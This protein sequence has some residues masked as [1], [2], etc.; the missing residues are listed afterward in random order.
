MRCVVVA[1]AALFFS[2]PSNASPPSAQ[3]PYSV[4]QI[5]DGD[6]FILADGRKVRLLGVDAP[7]LHHPVLPLQRFAREAA[8][9]LSTLLRGGGILL[10]FDPGVEK[11]EYGRLLAYVR[12]GDVP[13]NERMV[14]NGYAYVYTRRNCSRTAEFLSAENRARRTKRG[15]W[16]DALRHGRNATPIDW[17]TAANRAGQYVAVEGKIAATHNSGKACFLNFDKNYRSTLTLVVFQRDFGRFPP[18][19]EKHF[20]GKTVRAAGLVAIRGGRPEIIVEAPDQ[21]L[22]R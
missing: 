6:T 20:S 9:H 7:E 10:E 16:A 2:L 1:F 17:R 19:P 3:G 22:E 15:M 11:D 13:V 21:L 5:V 8:D 12:A 4:K 18:N 14:E